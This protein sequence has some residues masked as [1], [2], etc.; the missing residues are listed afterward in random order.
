MIE[1]NTCRSRVTFT[2]PAPRRPRLD[3]RAHP[4]DCLAE[5]RP[6]TPTARHP[7]IPSAIRFPRPRDSEPFAWGLSGPAPVEIWER[8]SPAYEAQ[9]ERLILA[10]GELGFA[11]AIGGAGSEDGEY[12]RA[13]YPA[14]ARIVFFHHLEDPADARFIASLDDSALRG[15]I[16]ETWLEPPGDA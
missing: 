5:P 9:L 7:A 3:G 14:D 6:D 16:T 10:L 15:W 2:R 12:V 13:E 4:G 8:F 11:P 1:I